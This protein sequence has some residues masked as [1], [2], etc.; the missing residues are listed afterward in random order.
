MRRALLTLA[1]VVLL[2]SCT[3][4]HPQAVDIPLIHEQGDLRVDANAN[5]SSYIIL[6]DNINANLTVSYGLTDHVALQAHANYGTGNAYG[7]AAAGLYWPVGE[8]FVVE[9]YGG[10]GIGSAWY[11]G[12]NNDYDADDDS[13]SHKTYRY[14]GHYTLPFIQ[15][16]AGWHNLADGHIEVGF[17][18][19]TGAFLPDYDYRQYDADGNEQVDRHTHL[20]GGRFLVEPQLMARFGGDKIKFSLHMG[21]TLMAPELEGNFGHDFLTLGA[22]LNFKL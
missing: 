18:L 12:T 2:A 10:F 16:N 19:K 1:A 20:D 4:Y 14:G 17:G 13:R 7:Q 22:G 11:D 8:R 5:L 15:A 9:T 21:F 6:P 3:V